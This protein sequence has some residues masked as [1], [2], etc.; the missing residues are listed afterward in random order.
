MDLIW[1]V[2]VV[3]ELEMVNICELGEVSGLIGGI[4]GGKKVE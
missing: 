4:G 3:G 2:V 1:L